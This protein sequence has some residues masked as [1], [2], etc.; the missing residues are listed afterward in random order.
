M[1]S[2]TTITIAVHKPDATSNVMML[3]AVCMYFALYKKY[4]IWLDTSWNHEHA[5]CGENHDVS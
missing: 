2:G 1:N 3:S 5:S 4:T